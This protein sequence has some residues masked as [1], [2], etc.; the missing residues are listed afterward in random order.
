[1]TPGGEVRSSLHD[2]GHNCNRLSR[3]TENIGAQT[4]TKREK[5]SK[6]L[7]EK[8]YPRRL[9]EIASILGHIGNI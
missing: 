1:M 2:T 3:I 7:S 5:T 9:R 8:G 6:E 4:A